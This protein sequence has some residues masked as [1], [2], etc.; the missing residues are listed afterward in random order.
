MFSLIIVIIAITLVALL[1]LAAIYYGGDAL[2]KGGARAQAVTYLNQSQQIMGGA[3]LFRTDHGRWPASL[4]ELVASHYLTSTPTPPVLAQAIEVPLIPSAYADE[5]LAH[6]T[7]V[8]TNA[9]FYWV[10][11]NVSKDVCRSVNL[12]ARGDN[13]IYNAAIPS[14]AAQCFGTEERFTVI[15]GFPGA[16]N[17]TMGEA[18]PGANPDLHVDPSGGGWA[19]E[20]DVYEGGTGTSPLSGTSIDFGGVLVGNSTSNGL[21]FTNRTTAP[22]ALNSLTGLPVNVTRKAG[23]G[24]C[25]MGGFVLAAGAS[26]RIELTFAPTAAGPVSSNV[27]LST[28]YPGSPNFSFG[29]TGTGQVPLQA[30]A[31]VSVSA[32]QFGTQTI[33]TSTTKPITVTNTGTAALT[34]ASA[35]IN[36]TANYAVTNGCTTVAPNKSCTVSVRFTPTTVGAKPATLTIKSNASQA[37][38][39]ISV[40]G[41]G[42]SVAAASWSS[43]ALTFDDQVINRDSQQKTTVLTNTGTASLSIASVTLSDTSN[44]SVSGCT[45]ALAP[46]ASCTLTV[47]FAPVALGDKA[48]TVTVTTSAPNSPH[49]LTLTGKGIEPTQ[50]QPDGWETG[51]FPKSAAFTSIAYAN[52]VYWVEGRQGAGQLSSTD[53]VNYVATSSWGVGDWEVKAVGNMFLVAS[54]EFGAVYMNPRAQSGTGKTSSGTGQCCVKLTADTSNG[55]W[56]GLPQ[57]MDE[58][59]HSTTNGVNW[60]KNFFPTRP[61]NTGN[62]GYVWSMMA[63]GN[64]VKLVSNGKYFSTTAAGTSGGWGPMTLFPGMTNTTTQAVDAIAAGGGNFVAMGSGGA[65]YYSADGGKTWTK[66]TLPTTDR[67]YTITYGDGTFLALGYGT[68]NGA[69]SKDGGRTWTRTVLPVAQYWSSATYGQGRFTAIASNNPTFIRSTLN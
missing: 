39:V 19:Q 31:L 48:G 42:E 65:A 58:W 66:T 37:T 43:T 24:M 29:V 14:L 51:T 62:Y 54:T 56:Y 25:G 45:A 6:W 18:V 22:V 38:Q 26:C 69:Y 64:G 17:P 13:G 12:L 15:L 44:Y 53:G 57:P 55:T 33:N 20:P 34:V 27:T 2:R 1:A 16:D 8:Q 4:D 28:N 46:N 32:L 59:Y 7:T 21:T 61:S 3:Q 36:D 67:Y 49:V 60:T 47:T 35:V 50:P 23:T 30:E 41:T 68:N 9:P 52:G 5:N 11:R 10:R 40:S 63:A